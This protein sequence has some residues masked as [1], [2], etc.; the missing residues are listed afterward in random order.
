MHAFICI[1]FTISSNAASSF[2]A[3]SIAYSL[4][5]EKNLKQL[6][7]RD[8]SIETSMTLIEG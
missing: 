3:L 8:I 7:E 4:M 5:V 6:Q 1:H 2:K